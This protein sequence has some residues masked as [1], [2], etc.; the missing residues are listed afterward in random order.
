LIGIKSYQV[1]L[2]EN[3]AH[4]LEK[5]DMMLPWPFGPPF[6][7]FAAGAGAE[8][9][10]VLGLVGGGASSSEKDSQPGS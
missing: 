2:K 10:A 7:G 5:K 4:F 1:W 8:E 3:A 6:F 9:L